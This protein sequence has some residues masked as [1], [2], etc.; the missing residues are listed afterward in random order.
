MGKMAVVV[1]L[2]CVALASAWAEPASAPLPAPPDRGRVDTCAQE[3]SADVSRTE[4]GKR[5]L[6][7]RN[8][9]SRQTDRRCAAMLF[10]AACV[11]D[12]AKPAEG[13]PVACLAFGRLAKT[14]WLFDV[15]RDQQLHQTFVDR[16]FDL[17]Q[18]R[19]IDGADGRKTDISGCAAAARAAQEQ[20]ELTTTGAADLALGAQLAEL[21]CTKKDAPNAE[22]VDACVALIEIVGQS[23]DE[24]ARKRVRAQLAEAAKKQCK[25]EPS[26][27]TCG[28]AKWRDVVDPTRQPLQLEKDAGELVDLC[29]QKDG[30]P[31]CA[32]FAYMILFPAKFAKYGLTKYGFDEAVAIAKRRCEYGDRDACSVLVDAYGPRGPSAQ[33]NER[34]AKRWAEQACHLTAPNVMCAECTM[35]DLEECKLRR[36]FALH[37]RCAGGDTRVCRTLGD[38]A[39]SE[40]FKLAQLP[41]CAAKDDESCRTH[42]S[43]G[44]LRRGCDGGDRRAC[45]ALTARCGDNDLHDEACKQAL[46]HTDVFFVA[47]SQLYA[48]GKPTLLVGGTARGITDRVSVSQTS[49]GGAGLEL[50]RGKLDA[51]LVVDVVL[52]RVRQAAISIVATELE[53]A[54]KSAQ[55]GYIADLLH[56]G[57]ELLADPSTL[58]RERIRDLGMSLVRALVAAEL[59]D[60][61][62]AP[63]PNASNSEAVRRLL[64]DKAYKT[65]GKDP[66]FQRKNSAEGDIDVTCPIQGPPGQ[67]FCARLD[68]RIARLHEA[69]G[70]AKALHEAGFAKLRPLI[71]ALMRSQQLAD[72]RHTRGLDLAVW[73]NV[74]AGARTISTTQ[75]SRLTDLRQLVRPATYKS[76]CTDFGALAASARELLADAA[77]RKQLGP[78]HASGVTKIVEAVAPGKSTTEGPTFLGGTDLAPSDGGDLCTPEAI[79]ALLKLR[80][81]VLAELDRWTDSTAKDLDS[82]IVKLE[83][84]LDD[85]GAAVDELDAG[86]AGIDRLFRDY[87]DETTAQNPEG[88]SSISYD[89]GELPL[90]SLDELS[91]RVQRAARALFEIQVQLQRFQPDKFDAQLR[92]AR[93]STARLL[94]FLDLMGHV[95]RATRVSKKCREVVDALAALGSSQGRTFSTPLYDTLEPALDLLVLDEP[96]TLEALFVVIGRARLQSLIGLVQASDRTC[97]S[98]DCWTVK[99]VQGLQESIERDNGLVRIDGAKLAQ[100]LVLLGDDFRRKHSWRGFFHLTVGVGGL[101]SDPVGDSGAQR[102]SVPLISEQIGFGYASPS[103]V[104]NHLTFKVA[105]SASGLLYRAVLDSEES[106]AIMVHP[107]MLALDLDDLVEVYVSPTMVLLYPPQ[108]SRPASARWGFGAGITVPL[109]SY[110][111]RLR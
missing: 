62:V 109:G 19:C 34:E 54:S 38:S 108:D 7:G 70:V 10:H 99:L 43:L 102:R 13:D 84:G 92:A 1:S 8:V 57:K 30:H 20:A 73:G 97:A 71:E 9:K 23:R 11:L 39:D 24:I 67:A 76:G 51:D 106:N 74:G 79:G 36:F 63:T 56:S 32:R 107:I 59:V 3:C 31:Y 81:R 86:I 40:V 110:L 68:Q 85:L 78:A 28:L 101:Y 66:L 22:R 4:C 93:T 48:G 90:Y 77:I 104:G 49:T 75:R 103:F 61:D 12:V 6:L 100:R 72:F 27:E 80:E 29:R 25:E 87:V 83:A 35:Y 94:A 98:G 105:S 17:G 46:I 89:V 95:A 5:L 47:E 88:K 26:P 53:R 64:V 2:I 96:M 60:S 41:Q 42:V 44:Y 18:A 91:V 50:R 14:G 82:R 65:L 37:D 52:D 21:G 69:L 111:E 33:R 15:D 45:D 16:A 58:R 55:V